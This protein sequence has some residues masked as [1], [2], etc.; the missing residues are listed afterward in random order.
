MRPQILMPL[1][2]D[3]S[4]TLSWCF[5]D[6]TTPYTQSVLK[7]LRRSYAEVPALWLIEIRNVLLMNERRGRV[8]MQGS[9]EFLEALSVLDIRLDFGEPSVTDEEV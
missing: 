7:A 1:V 2:I 8:T 5:A 4:M 3:A 6:E 9:K